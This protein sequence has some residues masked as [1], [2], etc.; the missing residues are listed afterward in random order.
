MRHLAEQRVPSGTAWEV[1]LVDNGSTDGTAE[2]ARRHWPDDHDAPLRIVRE[3]T[4]GLSHARRRGLLQAR[5][6]LISFVDDDN[7]LEPDWV[8]RAARVMEDHPQVGACGGRTEAVFDS[9][10]PSWFAKYQRHFACGEQAEGAGDVTLTRGYL[11]GAGLTL[12]RAAWQQLLDEG[13]DW[14]LS[15][16]RGTELSAGGDEELGYALRRAG[17]R[18]WYEPALRLWHYMPPGRLRWA[19]L[20]RMHR[21]FG[22]SRV[23]LDRLLAGSTARPESKSWRDLIALPRLLVV[24]A[25]TLARRPQLALGARG[26]GDHLFLKWELAQGRLKAHTD[27]LSAGVGGRVPRVWRSGAA[28][29]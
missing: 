2:A 29:R 18:L 25:G 4:L 22:A 27:A 28:A 13:F 11:W 21:G 10:P 3:E 20:R 14:T 12:R 1:I 16:R 15:D 9:P 17:W 19:Y 7:W 5:Y 26:E 8:A 23:A 24:L 6:E